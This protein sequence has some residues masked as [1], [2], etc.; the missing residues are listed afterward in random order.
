MSSGF[1]YSF[2][3]PVD[4]ADLDPKDK[5]ACEHVYQKIRGD[6]EEEI[7][8]LTPGYVFFRWDV[9]LALAFQA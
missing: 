9:G 7:R 5:D 3:A 1:Y 6:V 2:G 8:W 4:L